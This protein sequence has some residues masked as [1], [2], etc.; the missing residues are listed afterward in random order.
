M[1]FTVLSSKAVSCYLCDKQHQ[2]SLVNY[3][4]TT[5]QWEIRNYVLP[6]STLF[7]LF[8]CLFVCFF[9]DFLSVQKGKQKLLRDSG[10]FELLRV[11]VTEGKI[12]V[13]V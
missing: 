10:R 8:V 7:F 13:N 3:M 6:D 1:R 5:D 9:P 2:P 11:R 4:P 12:T